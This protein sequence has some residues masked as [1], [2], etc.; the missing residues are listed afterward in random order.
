VD[1]SE[2]GENKSFKRFSEKN[3]GGSVEGEWHTVVCV[4]V[5]R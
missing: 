5:E 2:F 3:V 4:W 1:Q